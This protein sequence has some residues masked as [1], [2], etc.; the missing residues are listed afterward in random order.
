MKLKARSSRR[1][2]PIHPI[3]RDVGF[4]DFVAMRRSD[5]TSNTALLFPGLEPR[6]K[7]ATR[8]EAA[9]SKWFSR[10]RRVHLGIVGD[11]RRK[12]F[13]SPRHTFK[14][15]C[16]AARIEEVVHDALTGHSL[17]GVGEA[18]DDVTARAFRSRSR[19]KTSPA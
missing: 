9:W 17:E 14:D 1:R 15:M 4:L 13:H 3:M 6:G 12:D 8:W 19:R 5:A 2:V 18:T 10:W 16:R 7:K 11:D